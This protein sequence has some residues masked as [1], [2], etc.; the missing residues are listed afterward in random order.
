MLFWHFI[1]LNRKTAFGG[2]F[3][4]WRA[5]PQRRFFR[6]DVVNDKIKKKIKKWEAPAE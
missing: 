5:L 1:K 4:V 6:F 2:I 3:L